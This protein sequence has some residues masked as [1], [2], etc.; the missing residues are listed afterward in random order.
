MPFAQ[1]Y[2]APLPALLLQ[3]MACACGEG[4]AVYLSGPLTTGERFVTWYQATGYQIERENPV[5]YNKAMAEAVLG[6]NVQALRTTAQSLRR[7][8]AR[9]VIEPASLTVPSWAQADYHDFWR[10][11]IDQF[12]S[13]IVVADG[14]V[15][16]TGCA[17]EI[18]FGLSRGVPVRNIDGQPFS[19]DSFRREM[20][21]AAKV[22]SEL[23]SS[24]RIKSIAATLADFA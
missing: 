21:R 1:S 2:E 17:V 24:A 14:W 10:A 6:P 15:F 7:N 5:A 11:V 3:S 4:D 16:S 18:D 22:L 8:V 13:E 23:G 20:S 9:T 12:A 19:R